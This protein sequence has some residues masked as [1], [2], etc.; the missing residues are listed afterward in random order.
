VGIP[1]FQALMRPILVLHQD[2]QPYRRAPL[3]RAL[4]DSFELTDA[5]REQ[6]LPSG[7]QRRFDNRVA[8]ALTHLVHAGLLVRPRRGVTV[9]TARGRQVIAQ[10]P[11][12]VDMGVLAGFEE[13]RQFRDGSH[14]TSIEPAT[15]SATVAAGD[16]TP[17]EILENAFAALTGALANDLRDKL[18]EISPTYFE[19]VVVDVLVAM[20]FGGSRR[21]AG[22]RLGETGDEGIDGVIREDALGLDAI[23]LQAKRWAPTRAVGRPEVQAFVGALQGARASKG[24]FITTSRFTTEATSYAEQVTPRVVLID[25]TELALLMIDHDVGVTIRQRYDL[26]RVDE[27]YFAEGED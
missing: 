2:G 20:G 18:S 5:D 15:S 11:D 10:H 7:R 17:E 27:D 24:V 1:D 13:Y 4:A 12:R 26:K 21:E 19:Q 23:Y 3:V 8:W 14:D 9:I 6:L 22:E 25:G 16:D